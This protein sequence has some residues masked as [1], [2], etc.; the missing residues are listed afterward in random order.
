LGKNRNTLF[1]GN[2]LFHFSALSST[3]DYASQ[4]LA[5][6]R[7][8]EGTVI[9]TFNQTHGKGQ[10]GSVWEGEVYSHLA[11]TTILYPRKV[12]A[13]AQ[14]MLNQAV[15]LAVVDLVR[16]L[17]LPAPRVKW[18]NDIFL[19][20]RKICG[21]LIENLLSANRIQHSIVGIGLNVNQTSFPSHL[22]RAGSL[23]QL[24][25]KPFDLEAIR[26]SLC[27]CLERRYLSLRN[28][29]NRPLIR[30]YHD[31]LY[32]LGELISFREPGGEVWTG[33]PEGVTPQGLLRIRK[34]DG[35]IATF[36]PKQVEWI[37]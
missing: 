6:S 20:D 8:A 30:E 21:I 5:K 16:S 19:S 37:W 10:S 23:R 7:P 22:P 3:N 1:I 11:F 33:I 12:P 31:T 18:P 26:D 34:P 35:Q 24:A 13:P 2:Q 25:G 29:D 17:S 15:A 4:L 9:S 27:V 14:F 32:G 28:R 36:Q